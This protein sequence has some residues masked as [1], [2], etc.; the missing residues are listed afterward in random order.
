MNRFEYLIQSV[1]CAP[2][3][4]IHL[5]A[6]ACSEYESYKA[7]KPDQV[8]FVEA[9]QYFAEN[10]ADTFRNTPRIKVIARA[11]AAQS[12]TQKLNITNNRRFS[13][14]LLPGELLDFYP[15]IRVDEKTEVKAITLAKLCR[16]EGVSK[17]LDNLLIAELQGMEKEVFPTADIEMLQRFKW[18]IIRSSEKNLYTPVSEQNQRNLPEFMQDAG[19]IA[20]VFEEDTP[21]FLDILCIRNDAIIENSELKAQKASH[22]DTIGGL[23]DELSRQLTTI[24]ELQDALTAKSAE[25]DR[26]LILIQSYEEEQEKSQTL[27]HSLE[28]ELENQQ[29]KLAEIEES[30]KEK[31]N[32]ISEMQQTLRINNKL[33]LR[34]DSDLRDLQ[35]QYKSSLQ[36]QEQ[37]HRLLCE[38]KEKLRQASKFYQQLNLK[39]LVLDAELLEQNSS[40][41]LESSGEDEG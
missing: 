11:I 35:L 30:Y 13:S 2:S 21:P 7:M 9:D 26:F 17:D 28:E 5:G 10:A 27:I 20:L 18:I 37:Q 23:E 15:N 25:S 6:G 31:L 16:D 3:L 39:N 36:H 33:I 34:S 19:F 22:L 8:I 29:C 12:G 38:L 14:L 32:Q 24:D 1:A 40:D 4:V 41:N